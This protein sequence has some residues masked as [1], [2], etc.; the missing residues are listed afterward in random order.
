MRD[1]AY[2]PS[3]P[4]YTYIGSTEYTFGFIEECTEI[5]EEAKHLMKTRI[6]YKHKEL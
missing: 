5:T 3:D 4:N 1:L 2:Y 6:R